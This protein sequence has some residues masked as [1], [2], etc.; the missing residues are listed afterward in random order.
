MNDETFEERLSFRLTRL[1]VTIILGSI[2]IF[3]IVVTTYLIA[4]T[5]L[6]EY[7]PGYTD[8]RM[9]QQV[10]D[11]M[12]RADSLETMLKQRDQLIGF[13]KRA[14]DGDFEITDISKDTVK[15]SNY[16]TITLKHSPEDSMLRAE[17]EN[18]EKYSLSYG[19]SE[20][21]AHNTRTSAIS[22]Y[23]FFSPV[24]GVISNAFNA[25]EKHFG[26]DIVADKN[27]AIKSTLD[28]TVVFSDWTL[29]TGYVIGV[30]HQDN[31]ISVYKH[32]S[33]LLKI[34]GDYVQAG[35]VIAII[36]ESGEQSTGPHLHFELWYN[37]NP[38]NPRDYMTF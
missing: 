22:S 10:Y 30:Q 7:I 24:R 18:Q 20:E 37:G 19:Y 8:V 1:N 28:G 35:E 11:N 12:L 6:R 36:G 14:L 25:A 21:M 3:L 29:E 38:V 32:N 34:I 33:A 15:N 4:F 5:P 13:F 26:V 16:D 31:L 2:A 17:M 23:F 27:E 9:R